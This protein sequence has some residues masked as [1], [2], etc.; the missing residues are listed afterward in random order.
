[1][2]SED[3]RQEGS[4]SQPLVSVTLPVYQGERYVAAAIE[5]VLAQTYRAL[6]LIVVDDGSTD[7]TA[8]V[9]DSFGD[10][11]RRH[12]QPNRGLS[13]TRNRGMGM[14]KGEILAFIDADDL[15]EPNKLEAQVAVLRAHP[16]VD[17]V[18]THIRQFHSPDLSEQ[19]R[20][21]L[22]VPEEVLPGPS[23]TT[24]A[25]RRL[26]AEKCGGFDESL[27]VGEFIDWYSR[28]LAAGLAVQTLAEVLAGRRIHGANM[29]IQEKDSRSDYL[30][31]L[32]ANLARKRG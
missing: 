20:A 16:E 25:V 32:R 22:C 30:K 10:R 3:P 1:M 24:C 4:Q 9:L 15:W 5:S 17:L 12:H 19:A 8:Q 26:A 31:V 18:F 27:R 14:A 29:G 21:Q 11:I 13:A 23:A 6:E 2:T 7:G 28:A